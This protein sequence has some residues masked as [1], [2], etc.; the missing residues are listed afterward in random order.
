MTSTTAPTATGTGTPA[1]SADW[2]ERDLALWAL[3]DELTP[4]DFLDRIDAL[5]AELGAT[6]P[7]TLFERAAARDSLGHSDLAVPLYREALAGGLP[8]ERHR[9][10]VVQLSSSLRNLGRAREGVELLT[11]ERA[12]GA[13]H[14]SDALAATL[15]L[16]LADS[17]REREAVSVAVAAL[18]AHLP[19]YRRSMGNYARLLVSPGQ[20]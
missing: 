6:H 19:R 9:R 12:R 11:A 3:L 18:A 14:L 1:P 17:G 2:E 15:A 10:A 4:A 16:C 13:D 20:E 8:G 5:T 7:V